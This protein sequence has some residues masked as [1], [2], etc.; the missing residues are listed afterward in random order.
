MPQTKQAIK[1]VR[2]AEKSKK[3]NRARKS[4]MRM[5][6]KDVM[7]ATD[8]KEAEKLLKEAV[9]YVDRMSVKGI[10][11]KNNAAR[12]KAALTKHVNSL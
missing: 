7:T 2:Q 9:S 12:K 5:L 1:R 4:K 3:H 10:V 11:H 8:K 6:I